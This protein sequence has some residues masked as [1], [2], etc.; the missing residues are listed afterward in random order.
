M[1]RVRGHR[2]APPSAAADGAAIADGTAL[3]LQAAG[4]GTLPLHH[5]PGAGIETA[6]AT[7]SS[8][9]VRP[10]KMAGHDKAAVEQAFAGRDVPPR[11][12]NPSVSLSP[13]AGLPGNGSG[14]RSGT[15]TVSL[16]ASAL[17]VAAPIARSPL[18]PARPGGHDA[19]SASRRADAVAI[20]RQAV[21]E[22]TAPVQTGQMGQTENLPTLPVSPVVSIMTEDYAGAARS[23]LP[24]SVERRASSAT[25]ALPL[26]RQAS[27][28]L[29]R[30]PIQRQAESSPDSAPPSAA[31]G[32]QATTSAGENQAESSPESPGEGRVR[33]DD[34][35][36]ER[37]TNTVMQR[38]KQ[39]LQMEREARGM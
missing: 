37:V 9:I 10:E 5:L 25:I 27:S 6:T 28:A 12:E 35:E 29:Q 7:A 33:L 30:F 4:A 11:L 1:Q 22:R 34:I 3:L 24:R 17:P 31:G 18:T 15:E 23:P 36:M 38:L 39:H 32:S 2:E 8:P 20:L 26:Q 21:P 13:G 16:G 14:S 19:P